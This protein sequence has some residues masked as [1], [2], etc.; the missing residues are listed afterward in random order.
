MRAGVS[1]SRVHG[2]F[3]LLSRGGRAGLPGSGDSLG[4]LL[5][6]GNL[7]AVL[8]AVLVGLCGTLSTPRAAPLTVVFLPFEDRVRLKEAWDL[9]VDIP[10]WFS[11][12]VD[13]IGS[14][15]SAV[16]CV[17]FEAVAELV[18]EN[19]WGRREY[20]GPPVMKGVGARLGARYVVSGTVERFKIMKRALTG[21]GSLSGSHAVGSVADGAGVLPLTAGLQSYSAHVALTVD[22]YDAASGQLVRSVPLDID[23][24]EG[25]LKVWLPFSPENEEMIFYHM[26]HSEFG[27]E[28]FHRNVAGAVMKL[29]SKRVRDELLSLARNAAPQTLTLADGRSPVAGTILDVS[30]SDIYLDIGNGDGLLVGQ[31]LEVMKPVRP[32]LGEGG[33]TL[34]WVE[35]PVTEATVRAIKARHFSQATVVDADTKPEAGW[36]VRAKLEGAQE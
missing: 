20:L 17:P 25:G 15:D 22:V 26:S 2:V 14:S 4:V 27:S 35:E 13:T 9:S 11:H 7:R 1:P 8:A 23:E 32:V 21:D 18:K 31:T 6:H 28:Y 29:C 16:H 5:T 33:D 3:C 19:R 24:K 36:S 10:R 12:T 34:G 30:G